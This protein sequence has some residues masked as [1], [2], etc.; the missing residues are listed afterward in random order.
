MI[1]G[2]IVALVTPMDESGAVEWD[3]L[4]QLVDWHVESGTSAIVSVGTTGESATLDEH[5]HLNVVA[6]T[7]EFAQGR[8][9]VI[10]GTGANCTREAVR[11]TRAATDLGV[12]GCLVVTP[13]YNKPTQTGL[14]AHYCAIAEAV[15]TPIWLYNV[16]G[17]TAVDLLPETVERLANVDNIVAIK[18]ST[19]DVGRAKEVI[20]AVGERMA[21]YSGDDH[22]YLGLI[23]AGGVGNISVTA[24]VVPAMMSETCR[25]ALAG[26]F[27]AARELNDRLVPLHQARFVES[28]PIPAKWALNQMGR[29]G[30]GIRLPLTPLSEAGQGVVKAAFASIE[31][32]L[33]A[34]STEAV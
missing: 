32:P 26:D 27:A 20:D 28:S 3:Q 24:N 15:D 5:E 13:Y 16:P 31:Q 9:P 7:L 18:E 33:P 34:R 10:A 23:E 22:S 29:I 12:D 19:G 1:K 8:L 4:R 17:R 21:V 25:L 14:F 11:W 6:K 30:P 2:S